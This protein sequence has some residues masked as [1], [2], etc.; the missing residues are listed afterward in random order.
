ME[1]CANLTRVLVVHSFLTMSHFPLTLIRFGLHGG[2]PKDSLAGFSL[3]SFV[4]AEFPSGFPA[5]ELFSEFPT[6]F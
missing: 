5:L 3:L 1:I 6:F 2:F 4:I